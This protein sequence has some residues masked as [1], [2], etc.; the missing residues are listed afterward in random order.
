M[1]TIQDEDPKNPNR[2]HNL[3]SV[4]ELEHMECRESMKPEDMECN[5]VSVVS[6]GSEKLGEE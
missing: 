4:L 5:Y 3:P 1:Q 2:F 6:I